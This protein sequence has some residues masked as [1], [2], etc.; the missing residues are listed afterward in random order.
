MRK[1]PIADSIDVFLSVVYPPDGKTPT[2]E[3]LSIDLLCTNGA[4]PENLQLGDIR[5]PTSSSPEFVTFKNVRSITPNVLP[6][7]GT[8]LLWQL[9]GH[10]SLNFL[11]LAT[12]ENLRALL[13]LYVFSESRDRPTVLANQ[14]R[15]NGIEN[16]NATQK[17]RIV[18]G[19]VVRGQEIDLKMRQDH[20]ASP[21]DLFLFGSVLDH[22]LGAYATINTYTRLGIHESIKG[23]TYLWPP[24]LG[25]HTLT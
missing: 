1:A 22:F 10:L 19:A 21:G 8:N 23:E 25:D 15:I 17:D 18:S 6:P 13:E 11:S 12:A 7:L 14:K 24:R 16:V 5:E 4:L 20:F 2:N 3:T 9:L